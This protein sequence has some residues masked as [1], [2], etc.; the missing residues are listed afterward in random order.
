MLLSN[1]SGMVFFIGSLLMGTLTADAG[2]N[3]Y[4]PAANPD[5]TLL[6]AGN[7]FA[8]VQYTGPDQLRLKPY[9]AAQSMVFLVIPP[10]AEYTI[11][12]P[13]W[14]LRVV[15]NSG[16]PALYPRSDQASP[17]EAAQQ[18]KIIESAVQ[19]KRYQF[20]ELDVLGLQVNPTV[21]LSHPEAR[22]LFPAIHSLFVDRLEIRVSWQG[23]SEIRSQT[24]STLDTGYKRLFNN[25]ALNRDY[26]ESFRRKRAIPESEKTEGFHPQSVGFDF[27]S[28]VL[29]P[30]WR[31]IGPRQDGVRV[32]VRQT[33][34]T[35]V[36]P[37]DLEEQGLAPQNVQ[38]PNVRIWHK[39]VELPVYVGD[40]GDGRFHDGD[41]IVFYGE[42]SDS[43]FTPD[44][45]YFL[46]WF[47]METP[48]RRVEE[49]PAAWADEGAPLFYASRLYNEDRVLVKE[50]NGRFGWYYL[51]MDSKSKDLPLDLPGLASAGEVRIALDAQNRT[52]QR[53]SFTAQVGD[54]TQAFS[55][56][57]D[58]A[59]RFWF[60][61]GAEALIA[62][63][64]LTL[65]LDREPD[66]H[67]P[68]QSGLSEKVDEVR[69]LFFDGIEVIYPRQGHLPK[70]G[71]VVDRAKLPEETNAI[72]LSVDESNQPVSAWVLDGAGGLR[73]YSASEVPPKAAWVLP[74]EEWTRMVILRDADLPGPYTVDLDYPS[75][76]HRTDQGYNY[77]IITH[78]S[79]LSA[80]RRLA[81]WRTA[82]GYEVLLTGVQDIYD[83]FNY[84]YP[85]FEAIKRFLR[86]TQSEWQGLSPDFVV[87]IGDSNWDHRDRLGTGA[88]DQVPTYA[89]LDN[90]QRYAS[91][92]WYAY[93]WGGPMDFFPDVIIGRISVH[94]SQDL[95][96]YLTKL[97]LYETE[98]PLGPWKARNLFITD[99]KFES[100]ALENANSSLPPEYEAAFLHQN[101]FPHE[102]NPY[103]HH[104]FADTQDPA[105]QKYKNKKFSPQC[106][107]AIL[108]EFDRGSLVVQ[109]IGH[110]GNQ[111]WS[112]ERIFYGT[113]NSTSNL[114]ELQPNSRFPFVVNW[115]CLTGYLNFNI[116][117]FT[118]CLSEEFIR[119]PDR[120]AI[121]VWGPSGGGTTNRHMVMSEILM[122]NLTRG[123]LT[124][125]GEAVTF[126]KAEYMLDQTDPELV[127]QYILFG[128]PAVPLVLP[129]ERA[130]V[131]VEPGLFVEDQEQSFTLRS[132][133][134][135]LQSGQAVVSMRIGEKIVYES[136]PFEFAD[137]LVHHSFTASIGKE[138]HDQATVRFYAWN[139]ESR[140]DAWGGTHIPK[141]KPDLALDGGKVEWDGEK[142]RVQALL[143]N[144][145]PYPLDAADCQVRIGGRIEPLASGPVPA[146]ASV[147]LEWQG[148]IPADEVV[149]LIAV[150]PNPAQGILEDNLPPP[151][152]IPLRIPEA[153]PIVPL[154]E[155]AAFTSRDLTEGRAVRWQVPFRNLSETQTASLAACLEGPGCAT[156]EI[157]QVTLSE[158][159]ERKVDFSIQLP[160]AGRHE[161]LLKTFSGGDT[162]VYTVPVQVEGK[163]DLALAEMDY[164][165]KPE[166]PVIG[167]TVYIKTTVYNVGVG[168]ARNIT[169]KAFD[170]DPAL[171]RELTHFDSR[172]TVVIDRLD[173]GE[174]QEVTLVWDPPAFDGLGSH[175]IHIVV[176]P[177]ERIE[178]VSRLNNQIIANVTLH[179]LPDLVVEPFSGHGMMTEIH[180]GIALWGQPLQLVGRVRNQG[181]SDAEY[182]R[183][184]FLHNHKEITHFFEKVAKGA[185]EETRI[186][187]PLH[188]ARNRLYV[189]ADR[190][191]LIAEKGETQ[192]LGNNVS[193]EQRLD[194]QLRMPVAPLASQHRIYHVT[195]A[196]QF[197]A[198]QGEYM[199]IDEKYNHMFL[200]PNLETVR[201]RLRPSFTQD[202]S[203][204]STL[205][206]R[207]LWQW[208]AKYDCFYSP[209]ES[210]I[211]LRFVVPAPMGIYDV[212]VH[213]ASSNSYDQGLP[214]TIR[215]K[216]SGDSDFQM[217]EHGP[218]EDNNFMRKLGTYHIRGDQ[219]QM[220]FRPVP[221]K[222]ST[223]LGDVLFVRNRD[224]ET[225]VAAGYLSP[226]FPAPGS[227]Q[228][229]ALMQWDVTIPEGTAMYVKARWVN[230]NP[231]GTLRFLPWASII[232]GQEKQL[233][234]P[235]KGDFFQYYMNLVRFTHDDASPVV[236]EVT[237]RV[238]GKAA[239]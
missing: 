148:T 211:P 214:Q 5:F 201:C 36:R 31:E 170:G 139:Q 136:G 79:M 166:Q 160:S 238:P 168:P 137:S 181:D 152:V 56:E 179:D 213:L 11:D 65:I 175:E 119:Y 47:E 134:A 99:N 135:T 225:P 59:T 18:K 120:G 32:R 132:A 87:L 12:Y 61:T 177:Q 124:R 147:T 26:I 141:R 237:I 69:H 7:D 210:D 180:E 224:Q 75:T 60:T 196:I 107:R 28:A 234:L 98:S 46:T 48:P 226:Y 97:F 4:S 9:N 220:E 33:G 231:D 66:S 54:A 235:G 8:L 215:I 189:M 115:S 102:T 84:G 96:R 191:D 63:P 143:F 80:A 50:K 6:D 172:R 62:S 2:P 105:M 219:F 125:V 157:K 111:L 162:R 227:G 184:T 70:D 89:P 150:Q 221:G 228:G 206:P 41:V 202:T 106:T 58:E 95:N 161:Y 218:V 131:S 183:F 64:T 118:V 37:K 72:S 35:A 27:Q 232:D 103:L 91:D 197:M 171:Q 216:G 174:M 30:A 39:G 55:L 151:L 204:F 138:G 193:H 199:M 192:G 169:V 144:R 108:K 223:I 230:Q 93:L 110:G 113:D 25:L 10:G 123:G 236:R 100:Y 121:A 165:V 51:D 149:A 173:P 24:R 116:S 146:G 205:L 14:I 128:D 200:D 140:L 29:N 142:A 82:Q 88:P 233:S 85:D 3:H 145:S 203:A 86:Y 43:E 130:E 222:A 1:R 156:G 38:L 49:R 78:G 155:K 92:E 114:L 195:E 77:V 163:P 153:N 187:V 73:K 109:Y 45:H 159:Q 20:Q 13:L 112:E 94:S 185:V 209:L 15:K 198:G 133:L 127:D 178:E 208:N 164:Q 23:G 167:R 76:L 42:A 129:Q 16:D 117:P 126:T 229:P 67:S 158:G 81:E 239:S 17:E 186:E 83:E 52:R 188:S 154:L 19:L 217:V 212:Y 71:L 90:P 207:Q 74:K 101:D 122:R 57:I 34:I 68:F 21:S 40:D 176:D 53:C 44:S 190:Y 22:A 104:R 182:V 194:F